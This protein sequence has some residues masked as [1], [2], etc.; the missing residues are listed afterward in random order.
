VRGLLGGLVFT[1]AA[2]M[3]AACGGAPAASPATSV[4]PSPTLAAGAAQVVSSDGNATL[5]VPQGSLPAG[6]TADQIK[7]EPVTAAEGGNGYALSPSGTQFST[8]ASISVTIEGLSGDGDTVP[9][10]GLFLVDKDGNT[11]IPDNQNVTY[12]TDTGTATIVADI[13][14]FS[15]IRWALFP[16]H[17]SI[18]DPDDRPVS[19]PFD[20]YGKMS[21][22][23]DAP[24]FTNGDGSKSAL[25]LAEAH[26]TKLGMA[27]DDPV[28][29]TSVNVPVTGATEQ[30]LHGTFTC[31]KESD[32][33]HLYAGGEFVYTGALL[34][35]DA[36]NPDYDKDPSLPGLHPD[37]RV[38]VS[39]KTMVVNVQS[40]RFACESIG[41]PTP[42]PTTKPTPIVVESLPVSNISGICILVDGS[43]IQFTQYSYDLP[44]DRMILTIDG[45]NDGSPTSLAYDPAVDGWKDVP[46]EITGGTG[47]IKSVI[48]VLKDGTQM[49]VTKPFTKVL[50]A[51]TI[52]L[53]TDGGTGP[54]CPH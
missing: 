5:T 28:S 2:V 37:K 3:I 17:G 22:T 41:A 18:E 14:H 40:L 39:D 36:G 50:G 12:S 52:D 29:P 45:V 25:A 24:S 44:I 46:F 38:V 16:V 4:G 21:I 31:G 23:A 9:L 33:V 35:F 49:D 42:S 47:K 15:E 8:P 13:A 1:A 20:G 7:V 10:P 30:D 53:E 54:I 6:V 19:Y 34:R 32:D 48:F 27:A 51:D 11:E 43:S 26:F